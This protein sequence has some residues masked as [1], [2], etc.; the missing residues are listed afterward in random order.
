[1]LKIYLC[2]DEKPQL[3]RWRQIVQNYLLMHDDNMELFCWTNKPAKLLK[4]LDSADS[5]GLYFL[6]IDLK[7]EMNGLD[8][9]REIRKRDPRGYL[10]F[11][12]THDE[13]APLTF[14]LKVEAMDF[15]LKDEPECLEERIISCLEAASA[16]Y[17]KYLEKKKKAIIV[18]E[19]R[20]SVRIDQ[21]DILYITTDSN[22]RTIAV[23]TW[24]RV[25]RQPGTLKE[26]AA[27]LHP[28]FCHCSRSEIINIKYV[29]EYLPA[30]RKLTMENETV[31]KVSI[32]KKGEFQKCLAEYGK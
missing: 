32:R 30:T 5:P 8:L 21:D 12:T 24:N 13:T 15:I 16:N 22:S 27:S 29:K 6:D 17:D 1:M 11:I 19:D 14:K 10:V 26:I 18:K 9:A 31:F 20:S 4:Y 7:T 2:E 3:E 23:Y 28:W 25:R